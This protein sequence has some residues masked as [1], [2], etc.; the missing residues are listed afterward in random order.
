MIMSKYVNDIGLVE[1]LNHKEN[2]IPVI[3]NI[4][5]RVVDELQV[6]LNNK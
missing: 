6:V 4:E 3:V 5:V 2:C 1:T